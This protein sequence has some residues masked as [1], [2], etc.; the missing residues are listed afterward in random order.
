MKLFATLSKLRI[1][2]FPLLTALI[3]L[4]LPARLHAQTEVGYSTNRFEFFGGSFGQFKEAIKTNFGVDL[5][6]KATIPDNYDLQITVPKLRLPWSPN[7]RTRFWDALVL[8]NTVTQGGAKGLGKWII[9]GEGFPIVCVPPPADELDMIHKIRAF[10]I[11][12]KTDEE[13][14]A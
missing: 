3:V 6:A 5:A 9:A 10:S 4:V 14:L 11:K 8:Y 12:A 13:R 7:R 1:M 2:T